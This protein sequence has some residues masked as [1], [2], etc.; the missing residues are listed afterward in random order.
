MTHAKVLTIHTERRMPIPA[1]ITV[2]GENA[3]Q[4][5]MRMQISDKH[6][7]SGIPGQLF[8]LSGRK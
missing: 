2:T 7:F 3:F 5:N 1:K 6:M 8:Q 4:M